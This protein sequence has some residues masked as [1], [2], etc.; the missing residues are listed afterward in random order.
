MA[1][2]D[3]TLWSLT[4]GKDPDYEAH[5][6]ERMK[7]F[8]QLQPVGENWKKPIAANVAAADFESLNAACIWFTGGALD[9]YEQLGDGRIWVTS[10]GYYALIGA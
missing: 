6:A 8:A 5:Q 10:P 2:Y 3:A 4:Q 7:W 9:V 1:K